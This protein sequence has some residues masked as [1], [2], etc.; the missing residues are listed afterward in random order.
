M[1]CCV[2]LGASSAQLSQPHCNT[3]CIVLQLAIGCHCHEHIDFLFVGQTNTRQ[4]SGGEAS[5]IECGGQNRFVLFALQFAYV[6]IYIA[7]FHSTFGRNC[8]SCSCIQSQPAGINW[9]PLYG[10]FTSMEYAR[11]T[12]KASNDRLCRK[13]MCSL[14]PIYGVLLCICTADMKKI[15]RNITIRNCYSCGH[16]KIKKIHI[17]KYFMNKKKIQDESTENPDENKK[18]NTQ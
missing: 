16:E 8:A 15:D 6:Y 3:I 4:S 9:H 13:K 10:Q 5:S 17:Q 14:R 12:F 18:K 2:S 1:I 7:Y 11:C